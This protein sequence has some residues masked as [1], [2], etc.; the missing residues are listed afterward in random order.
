M[1]RSM[2][3]VFILIAGTQAALS[4]EDVRTATLDYILKGQQKDGI[5]TMSAYL[6]RRLDKVLRVPTRELE[7]LAAVAD[8]VHFMHLS[9]TARITP[10]TIA[11]ILGSGERL[12]LVVDM[13]KPQDKAVSCMEIIDELRTHDPAGCA[14]YF[15][16]ILAISVVMDRP[17]HSKMHGQMG[18]D[19][20]PVENNPTKIYDYFKALYSSSDAKMDYRE[21]GPEELVFV[22]VPAPLSELEWTRKNV[23]GSLG[24]WDKKY[25]RIRYDFARLNESRFSWDYGTYTLGDIQRRGGIC[26]DQAYYSVVTARA[27]GIPAIYFHGSGKSA[28]HA[29]FAFMKG[30]GDWVL[31]VG[32]YQGEEYTTGYAVNPQTHKS[33][34]DHDVE[35]TC[36]RSLHS[37]QG[38]KASAYTSL[39]KILRKHDPD[40]ALRCAKRATELVKRAMV[41]WEIERTLLAEQKD[42]DGLV[43]LFSE[44]KDVFRKYPDILISSASQI[45]GELRRAG[46][47]A[48][49]DRLLRSAA[50]VVGDDRDD[51]ARSFENQRIKQ[52]TASGDMK[53]A[54]KEMEQM[55]DDQQDQG[56][57]VFPLI[58]SYIKL[59]SE[60]KQTHEAARFLDGYIDGLLSK[61][62]FPPAYE[63]KLLMLLLRVLE[64]DG[65]TRDA[66][67]LRKRIERM[68]Y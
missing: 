28:N 34:T 54:R 66:E 63:E 39:A 38:A 17:G 33:M 46:M 8:C 50:G 16:L 37:D 9:Q 14:A 15:N 51:L 65:L 42:Y 45:E 10:E 58:R 57:K 35:Y 12:R 32:R 4:P 52:I 30:R 44:M 48:E 22:V 56:N 3:L 61:Y 27:Y 24:Q 20:L 49:A 26:V 64:E 47:N 40:N 59:T 60:S 62:H 31:D 23:E 68:R 6:S 1:I 11:W 18:Q 41:P 67:Q 36:E 5:E 43:E 13:L 29:W 7:Q 53:K 19:L 21:L 2:I 55:L 25:Q